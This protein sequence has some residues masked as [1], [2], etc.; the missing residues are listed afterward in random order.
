MAGIV[1]Y[2]NDKA[3]I[4]HGDLHIQNWTVRKNGDVC[5]TEFQAAKIVP[6][7]YIDPPKNSGPNSKH[8]YWFGHSS[9]EQKINKKKIT[10]ASDI[11]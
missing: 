3:K 11:W 2:L 5:L 9:P 8:K 4:L 1:Q 6:Q 10:F 7:G